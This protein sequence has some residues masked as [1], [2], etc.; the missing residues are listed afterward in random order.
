MMNKTDIVDA[1]KLCP[2]LVDLWRSDG[3]K[4][5]GKYY[6]LTRLCFSSRSSPKL[7]TL[8]SKAI[9]FIATQNYKIRELLYLLDNFLSID[10]AGDEGIRSMCLLT[11]IFSMINIPIHRNYH[12]ILGYNLGLEHDAGVTAA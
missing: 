11:H 1:F 9:H 2:I 10:P 6:F 4:W 12:D 5:Q 8:L 3:V 7:F